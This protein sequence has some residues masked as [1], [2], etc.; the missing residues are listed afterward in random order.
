MCSVVL[1]KNVFSIISRCY[2]DEGARPDRQPEFTQVDIELSFT[3]AQNVQ[4]LTEALVKNAWP[5]NLS[6]EPFKRL[7][8]NECL[9]KYGTDKPDLRFESKI[10]DICFHEN[11]YVKAL[12]FKQEE[13]SQKL[14]KSAM[15]KFV[16]EVKSAINCDNALVIEQ[17]FTEKSVKS[18]HKL[19]P[20]NTNLRG[21]PGEVGFIV[22]SPKEEKVLEILGKI[23]TVF[24]QKFMDLDPEDLKFLWVVDF[25]LFLPNEDTGALESAHHPFTRYVQRRFFPKRNGY[26]TKTCKFDIL[27]ISFILPMGVTHCKIYVITFSIS[28]QN[29]K[30]RAD[31][32]C[33]NC[34]K[35]SLS[36]YKFR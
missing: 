36:F 7:T 16:S 24:S 11:R 8:Y 13:L 15:K 1:L 35:F 30:F 14:S 25:P 17:E 29:S 4:D 26:I 18:L 12:W 32:P 19:L 20:E 21:Q 28:S 22:L 27:E 10:E 6:K 3:D 9:S 23:R 31:Y 2:R 34:C 33:F 5:F